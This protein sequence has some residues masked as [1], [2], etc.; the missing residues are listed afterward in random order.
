MAYDKFAAVDS[1]T[2][3]FPPTVRANLAAVSPNYIIN[4]GFDIWQ[5]GTSFSNGYTADRWFYAWDG[6]GSHSLTQQAFTPGTAP[7]AGYEGTYYIRATQSTAGSGATYNVLLTRIEDVRTLAGQTT[8][9]SFWAKA[10]AATTIGGNVVQSFGTGGSA[11]TVTATPS[12]SLT[13]SWQRFTA[14]VTVPSVSGKTIGTN[15]YLEIDFNFPQNAA[16]TIDIWGVQLEQGSVATTFRRNANSIQGEL[17][18]CQRYFW[19]VGQ[20]TANES[21][22]GPIAMGTPY[23][24]ASARMF[25]KLPVTMRIKNPS[26][27]YTGTFESGYGTF[28]SFSADRQ[29][30]DGIMFNLGG[31]GF[32]SG[33]SVIIY[34]AG[35]SV[36]YID[37]NAEL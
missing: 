34:G 30:A 5:R 33:G 26:F 16:S 18:A 10:A 25:L 2:L 36:G 13:T 24:T 7:V 3:L 27:S 28:S 15:S 20:T 23:N 29:N 6:S 21:P 37:I 19:R 8:T 22:Y 32:I 14:T 9:L 17:A 11:V 31:S 1:S 4:G 35:G 12:F